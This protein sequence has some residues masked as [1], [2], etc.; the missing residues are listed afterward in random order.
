MLLNLLILNCF[1]VFNCLFIFYICF[2]FGRLSYFGVFMYSRTVYNYTLRYYIMH[3]MDLVHNVHFRFVRALLGICFDCIYVM[4][5]SYAETFILRVGG[6]LRK[7]GLA[8]MYSIGN[9]WWS[10]LRKVNDLRWSVLLLID[11]LRNVSIGI[12]GTVYLF[13]YINCHGI[14][15]PPSQSTK[16]FYKVTSHPVKG[17]VY[18]I[19]RN[20]YVSQKLQSQYKKVEG[21]SKPSFHTY[22][23][24]PSCNTYTCTRRVGTVIHFILVYSSYHHSYSPISFPSIPLYL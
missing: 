17:V 24:P 20:N 4:E 11:I 12:P 15:L 19:R 21:I 5:I 18:Y 1:T 13:R 3:Y 6:C 8:K 23:F 9:Q 10:K 7:K 2:F 16:T 22:L 14:I